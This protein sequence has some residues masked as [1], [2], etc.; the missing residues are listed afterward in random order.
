MEICG[1]S[2]LA[3][4]VIV[5]NADS[6]HLVNILCGPAGHAVEKPT[7]IKSLRAIARTSQPIRTNPCL[8]LRQPANT[9]SIGAHQLK[10]LPRVKPL[11]RR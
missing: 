3:T 6:E 5:Q 4:H 8:L 11:E 1:K 9:R 2:R 10:P 7:L